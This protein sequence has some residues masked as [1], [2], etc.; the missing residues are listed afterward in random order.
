MAPPRV[1]LQCII[2]HSVYGLRPPPTPS[3]DSE[4]LELLKKAHFKALQPA[5]DITGPLSKKKEKPSN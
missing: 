1:T 3:V 4:E 5:C 2:L